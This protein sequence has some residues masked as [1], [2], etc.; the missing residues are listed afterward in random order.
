MHAKLLVLIA[1][2]LLLSAPAPASADVLVSFG[3]LPPGPGRNDPPYSDMDITGEEGVDDLTIEMSS[4]PGAGV[5]VVSHAGPLE[6]KTYGSVP[7]TGCAVFADAHELRCS[8]G[9][10]WAAPDVRGNLAGGDDRLRVT[11][12]IGW[13]PTVRGGDGDDTLVAEGGGAVEFRGEAG[14]DRLS[15]GTGGDMLDGGP[16]RDVLAGG[17]GDDTLVVG[18][19]AAD[20]EQVDGGEGRDEGRF[21]E[22]SSITQVDLAAQTGIGPAR[23]VVLASIED[24]WLRGPGTTLFGDDG[25]NSLLGAAFVDGRGG[26]DGLSMSPAGATLRGGDGDDHLMV[27]GGGDIDAGPGDDVIE[28]PARSD[29]EPLR[30][31]WTS[32]PDRLTC[33]DGEDVFARPEANVVPVDCEWVPRLA[34]GALGRPRIGAGALRVSINLYVYGFCGIVVQGRT[35]SGKPVTRTVRRRTPYPLQRIDVTAALV[36]DARRRFARGAMPTAWVHAGVVSRCRGKRAWR[37]SAAHRV[38]LA[39]PRPPL[40]R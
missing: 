14:D 33:G 9:G 26:N 10:L 25:P 29:F 39:M 37:V 23:R 38:L 34:V 7:A 27:L 2:A 24:A 19:D 30:N 18:P 17:P 1:G 35:N 11:N 31:P 4:G 3:G 16:G 22:D 36:A 6:V 8:L 28:G 13:V 5:H 15:G 12:P 20:G 40:P 21:G 32:P